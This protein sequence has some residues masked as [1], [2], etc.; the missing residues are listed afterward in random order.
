MFN[1]QQIMA[2]PHVIPAPLK[3]WNSRDPLD[4]MDPMDAVYLDNLFPD[5]TELRLRSG[6]AEH[7]TGGMSGDAVE[8]LAEIVGADGTRRLV[9]CANDKFWD[10]TTAASDATEITGGSAGSDDRWQYTVYKNIG[11]F[12]NGSDQPQQVP[13]SGAKSDATYTTITDDSTLVSVTA[14]RDRLYFAEKDSLSIWYGS[15]NA[16]TGALTE[17]D[18]ERIFTKGGYLQ[19]IGTWSRESGSGQDDMFVAC[20]N[21]GEVVIYNGANPGDASWSLAGKFYLP[22]PLGRRA[23]FNLGADFIIL[24]EQG[25]IPLSSVIASG[26]VGS[27]TG[28]T[29]KIQDKFREIAIQAGGNFGWEAVIFPRRNQLIINVPTAENTVAHQY[30]MNTL[31]GAWCRFKGQN[32]VTWC[33]HNKKLYFGGNDGKV[34]DG[35][36]G[37]NDNG[38]DIEYLMKQSFNYCGS[39][40]TEKQ[41]LLGKPIILASQSMSFNY[42]V[43]V[44]QENLP[45]GSTVLTTA[46]GTGSDWDTADWDDAAWD[47]RI[48]FSQDWYGLAGI[49]KSAAI[50]IGGAGNGVSFSVVSNQI[51]YQNGSLF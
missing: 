38:A 44:D 39:R 7:T 2:V 36:S 12:V 17:F 51:I 24:T 35:D 49:G 8:T 45:F 3:G 5:T 15:V 32:A 37:T 42:D 4:A 34:Y 21:I 18:M 31:T 1:Q 20:S 40:A 41:F 9:G 22:E 47:T 10:C 29:D 48:S 6:F 26:K 30:V 27:Y 25:A 43:D 11:I 28:V 23:G 46:E 13:A 33:I 19:F 16:L 14:Y 50:K